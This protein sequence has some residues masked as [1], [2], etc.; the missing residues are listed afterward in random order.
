MVAYLKSGFETLWTF[1][2][3]APE[4]LVHRPQLTCLTCH[5]GPAFLTTRWVR[6]TG[7]VGSI[8]ILVGTGDRDLAQEVGA[9]V[10][11][12]SVEKDTGTTGKGQ[13]CPWHLHSHLPG[14]L[15]GKRKPSA[16]AVTIVR[17]PPLCSGARGFPGV[18]GEGPMNY[19]KD[20][21]VCCLCEICLPLVDFSR[22]MGGKGRH[23]ASPPC[24]LSCYRKSRVPS[25]MRDCGV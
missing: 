25:Q 8:L 23:S 2:V 15:R 3:R 13:P 1:Q 10:M 17:G 7:F 12:T 4:T 14:Q 5:P 22:E 18:L 20:E 21:N 11:G 19:I 6:P 16:L 9:G 24:A